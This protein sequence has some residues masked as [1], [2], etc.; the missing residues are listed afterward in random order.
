MKVWDNTFIIQMSFRRNRQS[1]LTL[2]ETLIASAIFVVFAIA[3][4]QL[5]SSVFMLASKIR[6]KTMLTEVAGEQF[7]FIRNLAYSDVG[8][9]GGIPFG[10]VD[11]SQT[12][13]RNGIPFTV[14]TTIRNI[15]DPADG[16]IGGVPNDLSPADKKLVSIEVSCVTCRDVSST[17]YTSVVA[18]KNL[19]TEN[20]NG[21][22]IIRTIDANGVPIVGATVHITNSSLSPAVDISDVTDATGALTIVDAPPSTQQYA[23]SVTKNGYSI[24]QTYTPGAG[25]NPNPVKPHLTVAANTI[26]QSTFAIDRTST[27]D[28]RT[29]SMLCEAIGGISG[30][31]TGS[32]LIGTAPD[33]IKNVYSF[34][35][36]SSGL[37]S[38]DDG[39]WDTYTIGLSGSSYDLVGTNPISPFTSTPGIDQDITLTLV[40]NDPNRLVVAVVDSAGLPLAG[41]TVEIDGPSGTFE[42]TT[43]VGSVSQ[44]DWS[45]GGGQA[46]IGNWNAFHASSDINFSGGA[47]TLAQS[48]SYLPSGTLT[49]STIDLGD[50]AM[51]Q[52]LSWLPGTQITG[53]GTG[54]VKFQIASSAVN[55]GTEVW[56]FV[57]PDNTGDTYYTSTPATIGAMH[58]GKRYIRYKVFLS[59]DD[60]SETP[61]VTDVAVTYTA[62]CLPPGQVN[63][64]NLSSGQY[65][66]TVSKSG[67]QTEQETI[68][69]NADTYETITLQP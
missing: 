50:S 29:Q 16:T 12:V 5:Y 31:L 18:P 17:T 37:F 34:V 24:E 64:G 46:T 30:S 53:L 54:P 33:V 21:A 47:I 6:V 25:G 59:T 26:S 38:V 9:A 68:T 2:I 52:E 42:D 32:K 43:G 3:I 13:T 10:I 66:I 67:F 58:D 27:Y 1:G 40:P 65:D 14:T 8:T 35:T 55:D 51:M 62:G 11:P 4:Y 7:E 63:V 41:A 44:T 69:I 15:D 48:G 60:T 61:T 49:S 20:G 57:G 28:I 19:E 36:N 22:L 23:V 45:N 56:T 39:E